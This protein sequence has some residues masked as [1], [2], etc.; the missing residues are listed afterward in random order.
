MQ[1]VKIFIIDGL[2]G[3][4]LLA[5]PVGYFMPF[6]PASYNLPLFLGLAFALVI[7]GAL[8][9][10]LLHIKAG[11]QTV[12]TVLFGKADPTQEVK[13]WFK[14]FWGLELTFAFGILLALSIKG[15]EFSL[16]ELGNPDGF[17]GALRIFSALLNPNWSVLHE[18]VVE[19]VKT[20]FIAFLATALAVPVA[21]LM[22]FLCA[23]NIMGKSKIGLT[24]YTILR[25]YFN[26][27]RSIEPIVWAIIF[28]SWVGIGP[29]AGMLALFIHSAASLAK[30]YSEQIECVDNDPIEGIQAT[31][32]NPLQVLWYA[33]VPQVVMP[34]LGFTI[35]RWDINI[36]MATIIGFVGGGGIG[37]M[38]FQF[39]GKGEWE[40]VGTIVIL[41]TIVVWSMDTLSSYIR[42]ALK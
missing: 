36:R 12:G 3:G 14:T 10:K 20:I 22:S 17:Q 39:Q 24:I 33:I 25:S 4:F 8:L 38:L 23:R 42:E 2:V 21:F 40:K 29:F 13:P 31:G 11:V 37:S 19:M 16:R 34:H 6:D 18:G 35:Y 26:I 15:T 7:V 5:I 28:S 30:L 32:A 41:V 27:T 1:H 9:T